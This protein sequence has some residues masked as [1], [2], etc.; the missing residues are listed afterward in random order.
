MLKRAYFA[1]IPTIDVKD[2][3]QFGVKQNKFLGLGFPMKSN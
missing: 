1:I 3:R 2:K